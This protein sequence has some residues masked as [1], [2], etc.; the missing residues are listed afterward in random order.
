[1]EQQIQ[2]LNCGGYKIVY[3]DR[4]YKFKVGV[5]TFIIGSLLYYMGYINESASSGFISLIAI[6]LI[7][8]GIV[9][10]LLGF[11]HKITRYKCKTCGKKW[12]SSD[13]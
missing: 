7:G 13:L 10:L 8:V 12:E 11:T 4:K 2:C 5:S 9:Y 3:E 1:M 6:C